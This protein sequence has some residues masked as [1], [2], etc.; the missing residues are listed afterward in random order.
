MDGARSSRTIW[1][2]TIIDA[3]LF[4]DKVE[5]VKIKTSPENGSREVFYYKS[6]DADF[7]RNDFYNS[8]LEYLEVNKN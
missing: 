1:D 5:E 7:F 8:L 2:L 4:P 6:I 3:L